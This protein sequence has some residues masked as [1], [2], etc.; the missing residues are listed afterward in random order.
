MPAESLPVGKPSGPSQGAQEAMSYGTC[1]WSSTAPV[2]LG[3]ATA[4]HDIT[5]IVLSYSRDNDRVS[6]PR[7]LAAAASPGWQIELLNVTTD[8]DLN[9]TFASVRRGSLVAARGA[10]G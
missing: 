8:A 10:H 5:Y 7:A 6:N 9:A 3:Y 2:R 1:A 4:L